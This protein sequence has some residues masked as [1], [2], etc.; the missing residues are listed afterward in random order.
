MLE[1]F[2]NVNTTLN[3]QQLQQ[4]TGGDLVPVIT[5]LGKPIY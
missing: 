1:Q 3:Q 5:I 2:E 4:I